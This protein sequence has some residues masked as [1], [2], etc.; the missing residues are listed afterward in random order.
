[1]DSADTGSLQVIDDGQHCGRMVLRPSGM[2][3]V[4]VRTRR[5]R[6]WHPHHI[7]SVELVARSDHGI[8]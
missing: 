7:E 3:D 8:R 6:H 1:V 5:E 4:V 2:A